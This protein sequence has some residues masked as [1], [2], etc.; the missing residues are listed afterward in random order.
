MSEPQHAYAWQMP[1]WQDLQRLINAERLPHALLLSGPSA[2]GKLRFAEALAGYL[3]CE[4]PGALAACGQCRSCHFQ[5]EGA[6]P[7]FKEIRPDEGKRQIG[8]D[9]VR[10]LQ[11]FS[12][13][14]AHRNGG[15]KIVLIHPA[16]AMNAN[17]ANALL[18][19]LEEPASGTLLVLVSHSSSQLLPTIRSRCLQQNFGIPKHELSEPWLRDYV[20]DHKTA[21][22]LLA[23]A[24]GRPLAARQIF[25][26]DGLASRERFD[27]A[28]IALVDGKSSP[29]QFAKEMLDADLLQV[30]DWWVAR[31][32]SL[33]RYQLA[34]QALTAAIW[35]R[36]ES[37][38]EK[39][40]I[41]GLEKALK[42]R[43]SF[44]RGV[45][46]NKQLVLESLFIEWT[47][48]C[49]NRAVA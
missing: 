14:H 4:S 43:A 23:E 19:T 6:N 3:L 35:Q 22:R 24:G 25:D 17:T 39:S 15:R 46:L 7:D 29:L 38:P 21:L 31:L 27:K 13:Q 8:V 12:A 1:Q 48:L 18:K 10:S 30:L 36:F 11:Q 28:L 5:G 49:Q 42:L 44:A 40:V 37:L 9:Q 16:E 41:T 45:V 26:D 32:L 2:I 20:G 33:S 47:Q 34:G